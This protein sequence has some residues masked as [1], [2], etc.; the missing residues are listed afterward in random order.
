MYWLKSVFTIKSIHDL[1]VLSLIYKDVPGELTVKG[2]LPS[3]EMIEMFSLEWTNA[4]FENLLNMPHLEYNLRFDSPDAKYYIYTRL[5]GPKT[6]NAI[7][8]SIKKLDRTTFTHHNKDAILK[9]VDAIDVH[10]SYEMNRE[11]DMD[12]NFE[13]PDVQLNTIDELILAARLSQHSEFVL[14]L[15]KGII[16]GNSKSV[17]LSDMFLDG[18][19]GHKFSG[20][21]FD[22]DDGLTSPWGDIVS[23]YFNKKFEQ[24]KKEGLNKPLSKYYPE[25]AEHF[26]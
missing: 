10:V 14:P 17:Y 8:P 25:F 3:G 24:W 4:P 5:V 12:N 22:L 18:G 2:M 7:A 9:W 21:M 19:G 13:Y 15:E 20:L 23:P 1:V 6:I 16:T 11:Y 26:E